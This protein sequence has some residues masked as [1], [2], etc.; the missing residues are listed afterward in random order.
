MRTV[1]FRLLITFLFDYARHEFQH[2][3]IKCPQVD[4]QRSCVSLLSRLGSMD[5]VAAVSL[6]E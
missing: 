6:M 1:R 5:R 4:R 3:F 2:T